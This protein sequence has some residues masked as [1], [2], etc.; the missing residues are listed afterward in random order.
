MNLCNKI[1]NPLCLSVGVGDCV[2]FMQQKFK[3]AKIHSNMAQMI[4]YEACT[5]Y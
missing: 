2:D 1:F 4:K 3:F 5:S